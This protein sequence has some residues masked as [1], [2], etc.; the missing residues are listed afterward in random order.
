MRT[1]DLLSVMGIVTAIVLAIIG[2]RYVR[3]TRANEMTKASQDTFRSERRDL[4]SN[5][6]ELGLKAVQMYNESDVIPGTRCLAPEAWRFV[7]PVHIDAVTVELEGV[8]RSYPISASAELHRLL[9]F[10][11][12]GRRFARYSGAIQ[13]DSEL[14]PGLWWDAHSYDLCG[15]NYEADSVRFTVAPTTYFRT[16]DLC[17]SLAHEF[18]SH[19][20]RVHQMGA[21]LPLRRQLADPFDLTRRPSVPAFSVLTILRS[22]DGAATFLMHARNPKMVGTGG[23]QRHVIPSGQFQPTSRYCPDDG[24]EADLWV[25]FMREF[26]EELLGVE[27]AGGDSGEKIDREAAPFSELASL[28]ENGYLRLHIL[29]VGLDPLTLWPDI[30]GAVVID[31]DRSEHL[32]DRLSLRNDE[33]VVLSRFEFSEKEIEAR[34]GDPAVHP[35]AGGVM[36]LAWSQRRHLLP[37]SA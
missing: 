36:A 15:F 22:A 3:P 37:E 30:M 10:E 26:A 17:E 23:D 13:A 12:K 21:R 7:P 1:S 4:V 20:E 35:I 6:A 29:G 8:P 11:S 27:E 5:R 34:C 2:Y 24:S 9:P 31:V 28:K 33:G 25:L 19:P 18:A 32:L 16:L 14:R